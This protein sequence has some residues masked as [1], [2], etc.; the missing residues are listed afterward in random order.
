MRHYYSDHATCGLSLTRR[1]MMHSSVLSGAGLAI[2]SRLAAA[3]AARA[4]LSDAAKAS[5]VKPPKAKA[6]I[7]V[8]L[9]GGPTH[10][11]TFDPKPD[12]GSDYTGPLSHPIETNVSGIRIGELLPELAKVADKYSLIR[13]MT[14]GQN[15]H[16][17]A[18]YLTQ[19]GRMPGRLVYPAAGAVVTAFK[20]FPETAG[21]AGAAGLIPPYIVLT[22]PMGRFSE[23]GFMGIRYKPFA[24]GGDPNARRFE[25]EGI[26]SKDL[27]ENQQRKRREFLGRL[28]SLNKVVGKNASLRAA[29]L[30]RQEAYDLI[31]G[32]AGRVFDLAQESDEMRERYGRNKFGQSCLAARRLIENGSKFV[33][34]NH[35]GWDTHKDHFASMRRKLPELDRGLGTL[36]ADLSDRGMLDDTIVWCIGE[37]GRSPKVAAESPWNG[38]RH[39]FGACFSSLIAGG[40]FKGG[41]IVGE[42]DSRGETVK[43]RPVYPG[44]LIGTMYELLGI[45][46]EASLPHPMGEFVR[47]TPGKDEGLESGGRL[48]ELIS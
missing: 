16:E 18:S 27:S 17:T 24:T 21:K 39:H 9:S 7:Q 41:Q 25:V 29:E 45:D 47:A 23:A 26:I 8:W 14:H 30:A 34:V 19:T 15:G 2:A 1:Q 12:S 31:V 3:D 32:D 37:F 42:S 43:N 11:D 35:G 40:G 6:V 22:E 28:N 20:G 10:T 46:P 33:T 36:I 48:T 13:S 44:D 38:G 5:V 4:E